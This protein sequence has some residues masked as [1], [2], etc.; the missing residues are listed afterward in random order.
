MLRAGWALCRKHGQT[1]GATYI[2]PEFQFQQLFDAGEVKNGQKY[3]P[4]QMQAE[5]TKRFPQRFDIP[6]VTVITDVIGAL[7]KARKG[8]RASSWALWLWSSINDSLFT[9]V[10]Q[11]LRSID[12]SEST[13]FS[14]KS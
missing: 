3:S 14:G 5:L 7:V 6:S 1:K 4:H 8:G 13:H 10:S 2:C 12:R 11:S 9:H